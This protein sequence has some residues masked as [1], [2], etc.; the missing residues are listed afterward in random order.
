MVGISVR[1]VSPRRLCSKP[2]CS[3]Q[4]V[5][6]LTYVYADST[7]VLGP[8]ARS[9]EPHSHDLCQPHADRMTAPRG[10]DVIR[11]D[12]DPD[13]FGPT[14]DDIEAL[15]DAVR[16]AARVKDAG[17]VIEEQVPAGTVE[18]ARRGHLRVRAAD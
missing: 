11:L 17:V 1:D 15:A 3:Q 5:A 13:Q 6:T 7:L 12:F 18:G 14:M 9:P 8:L 10:W 2:S 16:D 4:A